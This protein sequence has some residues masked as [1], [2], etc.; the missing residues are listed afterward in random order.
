MRAYPLLNFQISGVFMNWGELIASLL[1]ILPGFIS[2]II[3][4]VKE[5][6]SLPHQPDDKL[7]FA[8]HAEIVGRH[9]DV[10][11]EHVKSLAAVA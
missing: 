7:A 10:V 8:A 4:I 11:S 2:G 3:G 1:K 5:V 9:L 6:K